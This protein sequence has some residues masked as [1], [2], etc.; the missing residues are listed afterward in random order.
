[1]EQY[2]DKGQVWGRGPPA[3]PH[4]RPSRP[5]KR[6][7]HKDS[8]KSKTNSSLSAAQSYTIISGR[9]RF[10]LIFCLVLIKQ[11][12]HYLISQNRVKRWDGDQYISA[13]KAFEHSL[14]NLAH[15]CILCCSRGRRASVW[16]H[17]SASEWRIFHVLTSMSLDF[18][19]G[20]VLKRRA[21]AVSFWF[22]RNPA[23]FS[24]VRSDS[25]LIKT[26]FI[27]LFFFLISVLKCLICC[28]FLK[29]MQSVAEMGFHTIIMIISLLQ[30]PP[31][32]AKI[33]RK[34]QIIFHTQ[35]LVVTKGEQ[36]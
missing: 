33:K 22:L 17:C 19:K 8:H 36:I 35:T 1:M 31:N 13:K 29:L 26:I 30:F 34:N 27:F 2:E 3:S 12:L 25:R 28:T 6:W 18:S 20:E 4:H 7:G 23:S 9:V 24:R 32:L 10:D 15:K 5:F 21:F 14:A 11:L 16:C